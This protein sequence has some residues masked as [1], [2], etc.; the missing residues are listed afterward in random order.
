MGERPSVVGLVLS[1]GEGSRLGGPKAL[2]AGDDGVSWLARAVGVLAA[3]GAAPVYAVV[4]ADADAVR[5][6]A[7]PDARTVEA[8]DWREGMGASLRAGLAALATHQS[9]AVAVVVLLVDTPGVGAEVVE[10]LAGGAAPEALARATYDSRPGHPVV[11]GRDHWAGVMASASGDRGARDYLV[12]HG[13]VDVECGDIADGS[14][15]DTPE[16]LAGWLR[17]DRPG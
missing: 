16:A 12:E 11:I 6:A 15:I 4:G 5:A 7:P 13:V 14:D 10:R 1:A 17:G 2:V 3:G 8:T 9:G